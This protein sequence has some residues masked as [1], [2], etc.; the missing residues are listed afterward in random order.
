MGKG[1]HRISPQRAKMSMLQTINSVSLT[2]RRGTG[3]NGELRQTKIIR[4]GALMRMLAYIRH[5]QSGLAALSLMSITFS[6]QKNLLHSVNACRKTGSIE[7]YVSIDIVRL[8]ETHI[9]SLSWE[10]SPR[11]NE[12][13]MRKPPLWNGMWNLAHHQVF[14]S[15]PWDNCR[16][17]HF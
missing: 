8:I 15:Y 11:R 17:F 3:A 6:R 13:V 16:I 14:F 9:R 2:D 1:L 12:K 4:H 7:Q 10:F 5:I